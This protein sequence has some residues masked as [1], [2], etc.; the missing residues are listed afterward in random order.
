MKNIKK[1]LVGFFV[2]C[3]CSSNSFAS[4]SRSLTVFAEQNM[5]SSL[6]KISR[7]YC[8]KNHVIVSVNF[9]S[10]A[11]LI[12]EVDAGEPA[13]IFISAH[14]GW[15][16]ALRQKGLTDVYNTG[17][18][19]LDRLVI[20]ASVNNLNIPAPLLE[21]KLSVEN[22][23]QVLNQK[24]AVLLA[25]PEGTSSGKFS[26]DLVKSLGLTDLQLF[27]KLSE[28]RSSAL[29]LTGENLESYAILLGSQVNYK[30]DL[31]ILAHQKNANISYQAVVIAG[32]NMDTA[33]EFLK[34]LKTAPAK[35]ILR[36]NGFVVD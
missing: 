25:D 28:D 23:L 32:D 20:V 17:H 19:A 26:N 6:V 7:L 8:Q 21:K 16:D 15:I 18:I 31:K 27:T 13:D 34:F 9:N 3:L 10:S 35:K 1:I 33:R 36:D 24:K 5:V 22:A 4:P 12:N 14:S 11:E 30:S 2:F 29:E